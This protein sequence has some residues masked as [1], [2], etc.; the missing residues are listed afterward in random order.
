MAES[1][2][3][4]AANLSLRPKQ[5]QMFKSDNPLRGL[6]Q[7]KGVPSALGH[8]TIDY[9]Y[10]PLIAQ[11]RPIDALGSITILIRWNSSPQDPDCVKT[12]HLPKKPPSVTLRLSPRDEYMYLQWNLDIYPWVNNS[13]VASWKASRQLQFRFLTRKYRRYARIASIRDFTPMIFITRFIL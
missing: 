3:S 7:N 1:R 5:P 8:Q 11:S 13:W 10:W 12:Q 2:L 4:L 9:L 6:R